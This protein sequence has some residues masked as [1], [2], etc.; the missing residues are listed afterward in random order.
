MQSLNDGMSEFPCYGKSMKK[1]KHS[2]V[3][4]FLHI[5]REAE[6]HKIPKRW[7]ERIPILQ[8]K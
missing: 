2:K 5:S 7:D 3:I 6:I 1:H 8:N 4:G